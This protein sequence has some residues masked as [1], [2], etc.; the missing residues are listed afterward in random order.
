M[1]NS[2]YHFTRLQILVSAKLQTEHKS[3]RHAISKIFVTGQYIRPSNDRIWK[4]KCGDI[5]E[6]AECADSYLGR[7]DFRYIYIRPA[8]VL[9][10]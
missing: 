3:I 7:L 1:K 8:T 4:F 9:L 2:K 5:L 6:A 10:Q